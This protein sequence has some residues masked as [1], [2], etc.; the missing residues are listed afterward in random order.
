[1]GMFA[2][3][4]FLLV[5]VILRW[6]VR[7]A[8]LPG[9]GVLSIVPLWLELEFLTKHGRVDAEGVWWGWLSSA[10]SFCWRDSG[11]E[12]RRSPAWPVVMVIVLCA[13]A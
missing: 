1:M 3:V 10:H 2:A 12:A 5:V 8:S 13:G 9:L 4:L 11:D 7:I 6:V